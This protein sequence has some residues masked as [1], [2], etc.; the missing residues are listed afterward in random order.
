[1]YPTLTCLV[2]S[3]ACSNSVIR[4]A[5][6]LPT[7]PRR[8]PLR[9][10]LGDR[11]QHSAS[12]A[13]PHFALHPCQICR[14]RCF[15]ASLHLPPLPLQLRF[16]CAPTHPPH[17][18]S[19][20]RTLDREKHNWNTQIMP[21]SSTISLLD[22]SRS[23]QGQVRHPVLQQQDHHRH[24]RPRLC[25][26]SI[27]VPVELRWSRRRNRFRTRP[28]QGN[29]L[30]QDRRPQGHLRRHLEHELY[31]GF[32]FSQNRTFFHSFEGDTCLIGFSFADESE[33][34]ELIEKVSNRSKYPKSKS[35]VKV[36]RVLLLQ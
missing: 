3:T 27:P 31:D 10:L 16:L 26:P 11:R 36:L 24:R 8:T 19:C 21:S 5:L 7:R 9:F 29:L 13:R 32:Q 33:A 1:M 15:P 22:K 23:S 4:T 20:H 25:C 30:L 34:S 2:A 12:S 28:L 18:L 6:S 14:R 17:H 35:Q